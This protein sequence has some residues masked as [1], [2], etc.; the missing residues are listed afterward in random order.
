MTSR[1][2]VVG[3]ESA[4]AAHEAADD[5]AAALAGRGTFARVSALE[6]VDPRTAAVSP[7]SV[8][9]A[10]SVSRSA[11]SAAPPSRSVPP[12]GKKRQSAAGPASA[13]VPPP[14]RVC[15]APRQFLSIRLKSVA[16][17]RQTVR[18]AP[19]KASIVF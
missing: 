1:Y 14:R 3:P 13:S 15:S 8:S 17:P 2:I 5:L 12:A 7:A 9:T 11:R 10:S 18:S 4:N 6:G 16:R 19:E